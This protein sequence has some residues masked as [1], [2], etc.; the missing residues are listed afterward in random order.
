MHNHIG[1]NL[2]AALVAGVA[3]FVV[4]TIAPAQTAQDLVGAWQAVSVVNTAKDGAKSDVFGPDVK[5]I[6]IFTSDGRFAFVAMRAV[7][8]KF[9]SGNRMQGTPDEN[10]AVVQGSQAYFGTY[11][12]ADKVITFH[13]DAST[14]PAWTGTDQKRSI[15]AFSKDE[16]T[17]T[18][19]A[20]IGGTNTSVWKRVK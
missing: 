2:F 19:S 12:V 7:L 5:G 6:C 18:S 20:A 13:V 15:T 11:S 17:Q 3:T 4:P 14:W 16:M 8:P 9:A 10:K 1:F